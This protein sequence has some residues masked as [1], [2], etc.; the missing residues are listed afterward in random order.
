MVTIRKADQ[1]D[2]YSIAVVQVD[3][4]R[5]T[6]AGIMPDDYLNN[7]SYE[8]KADSWKSRLFGNGSSEIMYVAECSENGIVGFTAA[9]TIKTDD[10]Y[11]RELSAI[12]ILNEFQGRG[13]G[14]SLI[15]A[16]VSDYI[17]ENVKSMI[18]WT[19]EENPAR[20]FYQRI[21]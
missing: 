18:L 15:E 9:S 1:S 6:Y 17:S 13:I 3:S 7:L 10:F 12:Y 16:V 11:E 20:Q 21:G 5:S 8:D 2:L 14:K 4:N 19:L